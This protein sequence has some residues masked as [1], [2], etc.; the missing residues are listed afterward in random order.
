MTVDCI[1]PIDQGGPHGLTKEVYIRLSE[2]KF[3]RA[4]NPDDAPQNKNIDAIMAAYRS[5]SLQVEFGKVPYWANGRQISPLKPM[6]TDEE[7][8]VGM[9]NNAD[10]KEFWVG[11]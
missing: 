4:H 11:M 7:L 9:A 6:D 2:L 8:A 5:G 10:K 3:I 1:S